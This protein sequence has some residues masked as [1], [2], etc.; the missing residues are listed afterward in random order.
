MTQPVFD[1][2][3][4]FSLL[5]IGATSSLLRTG[6]VRPTVMA[7]SES[8]GVEAVSLEWDDEEG[9]P[10]AFEEARRYVRDLEPAGYAVVAHV[11]RN[12]AEITYH[13]PTDRPSVPANDFLALAMF[14]REGASRAATYPIR[15]MAGKISLAMP[16]VTDARLCDWHPIGDLWSNPFCAGDLVRF[17]PGERPVDP[18]S[19]LWKL[20]VELT[21]MRI[22]DDQDHAD[23]YMSFLDDLRNG[24][25]V[26]AGRSP[27]DPEMVVLKPRTEFN[28]LGAVTVRSRSLV[29]GESA[30][31]AVEKVA[32][33]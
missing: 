29:L 11:T 22:Q 6:T 23:E 18:A 7:F 15:R 8:A 20:M 32:V 3:A 2:E 12:N 10:R 31:P 13:L 19:P 21:R 14:S 16:T 17:K 24:V 30:P 27:R 1:F 26:V 9:I 28:P 4:E 25:F 5:D 33:S